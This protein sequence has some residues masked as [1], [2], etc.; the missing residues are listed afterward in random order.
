M[1]E[2]DFHER[3][4]KIEKHLEFFASSYKHLHNLCIQQSQIR[5][6]KDLLEP[7]LSNMLSKMK[8]FRDLYDK[9]N[10][11]VNKDSVLG[12]LEFMAKRLHEMESTISKLKEEGIKKKI[13]LDFTVDGYEMVRRKS[14]VHDMNNESHE[15]SVKK[16]LST[17]TER[18]SQVLIHRY[19]LF[20]KSAKTLDATGEY[21]GVT[22]E[23]VRQIQ[24]KALRKCRHPNRK[25]LVDALTHKDLRKDILGDDE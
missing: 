2:N 4:E 5:F 19:G 8:E 12:T 18:E 1:N 24:T 14:E 25:K 17:L 6:Q 16:L 3:L 11:I 13:Q 21:I 10:D 9:I 23:R 22:R 15:D 7:T 20:G